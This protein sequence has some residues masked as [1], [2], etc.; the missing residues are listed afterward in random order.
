MNTSVSLDNLSEDNV[1]LYTI[2]CNESNPALGIL[3]DLF[4]VCEGIVWAV[5][6]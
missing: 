3:K 6:S 4:G 2:V 5:A 1:I